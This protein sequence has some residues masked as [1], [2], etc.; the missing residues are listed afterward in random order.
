MLSKLRHC[1]HSWVKNERWKPK[2]SATCIIIGKEGKENALARFEYF[3][4]ERKHFNDEIIFRFSFLIWCQNTK[5]F[6]NETLHILLQ[7]ESLQEDM[8]T[9]HTRF[10]WC[11][12]FQ[13]DKKKKKKS[14]SLLPNFCFVKSIPWCTSFIIINVIGSFTLATAKI[15]HSLGRKDNYCQFAF[16]ADASAA[17]TNTLRAVIMSTFCGLCSKLH[18]MWYQFTSP[19]RTGIKKSHKTS[20]NVHKPLYCMSVCR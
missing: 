6:K 18:F 2:S 15:T 12:C 11:H 1:C 16:A 10:F 8:H 7:S 4:T 17:Q 3:P 14:K 5:T 19:R 9:K 20:R 13:S